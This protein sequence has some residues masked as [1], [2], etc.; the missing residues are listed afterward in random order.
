MYTTRTQTHQGKFCWY[1]TYS[2]TDA[3]LAAN[4][5][6][7]RAPIAAC[8]S[9]ERLQ[10]SHSM[11]SLLQLPKCC[12]VTTS[13]CITVISAHDDSC[14]CYCCAVCCRSGAIREG[15]LALCCCM[16]L[17]AAQRA[18]M[19]SLSRYI[20]ELLLYTI[21]SYTLLYIFKLQFSTSS[22]IG[23]VIV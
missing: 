5:K 9:R 18:G 20:L 2:R 11:F 22:S 16:A 1:F 21:L 14:D 19:K 15:S 12:S 7:S 8:C 4:T 13:I 3:V 10:Q 6:I 23:V 17:Q